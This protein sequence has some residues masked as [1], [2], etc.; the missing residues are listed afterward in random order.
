M[1]ADNKIHFWRRN[2]KGPGRWAERSGGDILAF[3]YAHL[4]VFYA[5]LICL[6]SYLV[7]YSLSA[8]WSVHPECFDLN[9]LVPVNLL[10]V[11]Q[12]VYKQHQ[13]HRR[14]WMETSVSRCVQMCRLERTWPYG[15]RT[16]LPYTQR[17]RLGVHVPLGPMCGKC[18]CAGVRRLGRHPDMGA[19][20]RQVGA[21]QVQQL[22]LGSETD[23]D[24]LKGPPLS[25]C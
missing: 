18:L 16:S 13:S 25:R 4:P 12:L 21:H 5:F 2:A 7:L 9:T 14:S 23:P 6:Y 15:M 8:R 1:A 22:I 3:K 10:H 24:T 11:N 20:I 19:R 17:A